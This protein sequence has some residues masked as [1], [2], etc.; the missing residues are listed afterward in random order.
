M[1]ILNLKSKKISET[2]QNAYNRK[3]N[4]DNKQKIKYKTCL[5]II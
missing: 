3:C 2:D 1:I 4:T 5:F